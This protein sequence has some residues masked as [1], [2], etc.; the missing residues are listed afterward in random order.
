MEILDTFNISKKVSN[1]DITKLKNKMIGDCSTRFELQELLK[2]EL[3][4]ETDKYLQTHYIPGLLTPNKGPNRPNNQSSRPTQKPKKRI[5]VKSEKF[6][7]VKFNAEN[8]AKTLNENK[9]DKEEMLF[10]VISLVNMLELSEDDF[11]T[12]HKK[13]ESDDDFEEMDD[14]DSQQIK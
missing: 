14:D 5:N 4:N 3:I 13:M 11:D 9:L 8:L 6:V 12:F 1:T 7:R 10:F 2:E